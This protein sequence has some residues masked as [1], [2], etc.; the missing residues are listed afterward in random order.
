MLEQYINYKVRVLAQLKKG[1]FQICS[2]QLFVTRTNINTKGTLWDFSTQH[3]PEQQHWAMPMGADQLFTSGGTIS[4]K[5][6][7]ATWEK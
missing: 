5:K 6:D 3:Y 4:R 1:E 7:F 2:K